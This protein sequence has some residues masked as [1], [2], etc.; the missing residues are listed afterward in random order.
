MH[1]KQVGLYVAV[2]VVRGQMWGNKEGKSQIG[3]ILST[4]MQRLTALN[5]WPSMEVFLRL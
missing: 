2:L 5:K 1:G 3:R 4:L